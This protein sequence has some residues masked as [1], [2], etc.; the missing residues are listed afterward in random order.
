MDKLKT[1]FGWKYRH[2]TSPRRAA[3]VRIERIVDETAYD[4]TVLKVHFGRLTLKIYDKGERVCA[5]RPSYTTSKI[6][7]AAASWR[8]FRSC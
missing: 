7:D 8:S 1:I 4:V 5:W 3:S 2:I 6:Y